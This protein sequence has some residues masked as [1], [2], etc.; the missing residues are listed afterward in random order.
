MVLMPR[1]TYDYIENAQLQPFRRYY[2]QFWIISATINARGESDNEKNV[3]I[4]VSMC[5]SNKTDEL[6]GMSAYI[7]E[8]Q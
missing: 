1:P 4:C 7:T 6:F 2:I 8:N 5:R 3:F